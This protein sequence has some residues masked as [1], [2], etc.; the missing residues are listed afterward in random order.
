[1]ITTW[2]VRHVKAEAFKATGL[3][4]TTWS[5]GG[6]IIVACGEGQSG[7]SAACDLEMA[8]GLPC[9]QRKCAL[10]GSLADIEAKHKLGIFD[11]TAL[12]IPKPCSERPP[13]AGWAGELG[14]DGFGR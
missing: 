8:C 14:P 13:V 5:D 2:N 3:A 1:M 9:E 7:R 4:L 6:V 10:T 11:Q 12:V